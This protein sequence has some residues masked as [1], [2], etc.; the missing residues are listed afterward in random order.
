MPP[1]VAGG[2]VSQAELACTAPE[3]R[4]LSISRRRRDV[5]ADE[6]CP[7][8]TPERLESWGNGTQL[9]DAVLVDGAVHKTAGP[10]TPAVFAL[11]RHLEAAAFA[12]AQRVV[13]DGYSF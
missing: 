13:G 7:M 12:G 3:T 4:S 5:T 11:L 9:A 8:T 1:A 2:A 6:G 10:W